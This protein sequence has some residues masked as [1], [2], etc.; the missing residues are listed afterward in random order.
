VISSIPDEV[1]AL[2]TATVKDAAI[3]DANPLIAAAIVAFESVVLSAAVVFAPNVMVNVPPVG[4]HDI[5]AAMAALK[6]FAVAF[7]DVE[8]THA[9][10]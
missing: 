3:T 1:S 9:P 8:S 5:V 10:A 2:V 4:Y 6:M 7:E